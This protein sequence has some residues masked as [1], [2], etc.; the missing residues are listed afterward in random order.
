MKSKV[1]LLSLCASTMAFAA[2]NQMNQNNH[3]STPTTQ[4]HAVT[5]SKADGEVI[6]FLVVLDQ[7]EMAAA[8]DAMSKKV[9][10]KVKAYAK[11]MWNDHNQN[12]KKTMK[13]SKKI[14]QA[15][16]QNSQVASLQRSGK[17][18]ESNLSPLND[19]NF[20]IAYIDAM[21][22]G[23]EEALVIIDRNMGSVTNSDL[24]QHLKSTRSHVQHHLNQAKKIQ[25]SL[26][27][28]N[29]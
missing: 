9:N 27:T 11:M 16:L 23:H 17:K 26:K 15:P 14:N 1:L 6:G 25:Q 4:Q 3:M 19:R 12:L 13:I 20:E 10:P 18:M 29:S 21:V 5:S 7:N 28:S 22:K 2:S 24:K 8:K